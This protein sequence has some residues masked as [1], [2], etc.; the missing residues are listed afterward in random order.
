MAIAGKIR[1]DPGVATRTRRENTRASAPEERISTSVD[2]KIRAKRF[3]APVASNR[4]PSAARL[5]LDRALRSAEVDIDDPVGTDCGV[6]P[7][8]EVP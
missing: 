2:V 5:L 4:L 8:T 3:D 1:R 7:M 6:T